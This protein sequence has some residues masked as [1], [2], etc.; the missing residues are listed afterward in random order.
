MQR[1]IL[2]GLAAFRWAGWAWMATVL[3]VARG[4]LRLPVLAVALVGAA[5]ALTATLTLL[6]RRRP[7]LLTRPATVAVEV[8][9]GVA[10]IAADGLVYGRGHAFSTSQSLGV[11]W[12]LSG[13]LAA[14]TI[15][16]PLT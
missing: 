9:L 2:S 12:P 1:G 7:L 16:G 6:L 14:G 4:D 11:A 13:V 5:L 3:V 15:F 8:A 10:L